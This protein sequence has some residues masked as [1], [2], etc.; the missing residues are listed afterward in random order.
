MTKELN[1]GI[2]GYKFMGRAHSNAWLKAPLFFDLPAKPVLKTACGRQE[3]SLKEFAEKWGW[4][5]IETDWKK[6]VSSPD[7]DIVDIALPQNLH[8]EI[9]LAAAKEG[10][11]IFCEKPLSM[12]R[13]QA[14]EMLRVCEDH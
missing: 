13:Q 14:E 9:A 11:H 1:V 10:K 12:N 2:V 3:K 7:I 5:N 4:E 6:L 8:Y